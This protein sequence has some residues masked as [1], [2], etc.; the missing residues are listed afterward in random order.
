M[1][2][3]RAVSV[4]FAGLLLTMVIM[5]SFEET[6]SENVELSFFVPLIV[7]HAGNT[8]S[9][10]V[11]TVIRALALGEATLGD[12]IHITTKEF[13]TGG[14]IGICL[15]VFSYPLG[16]YISGLP[17]RVM[18]SVAVSLPAVSCVANLIGAGLPLCCE[19][20]QLDPAV[21]AAPM[22]TTM[23][24][25]SG[26]LTY[27]IISGFVIGHPTEEHLEAMEAHLEREIE[28]QFGVAPCAGLLEGGDAGR[29][30]KE[31]REGAAP[32][33]PP[34]PPTEEEIAAIMSAHPDWEID[35]VTGM[36]HPHVA[37][38]GDDTIG[39]FMN[40][41][42]VAVLCW[43]GYTFYKQR[44][45]ADKEEQPHDEEEG[46]PNKL[47]PRTLM[48]NVRRDGEDEVQAADL[49]PAP[50]EKM[51]STSELAGYFQEALSSL[52]A[53]GVLNATNA[54]A[55]VNAGKLIVAL[56]D[57]C[58]V[59]IVLRSETYN[60]MRLLQTVPL[61]K[62]MTAEELGRIAT[63]VE[64]CRYAPGEK[65]ITEGNTDQAMFVVASGTAVCTK[66][67]VNDGNP[68]MNYSAGDFF[69]ERA[70]RESHRSPQ[71]K[72][73]HD[74]DCVDGPAC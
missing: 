73:E 67:G 72:L 21:I 28:E 74:T 38:E 54:N 33:P 20:L 37:R 52:T 16:V 45:A 41:C 30:P 6:L 60:H 8:G 58:G 23:V 3:P 46:D 26:I 44:T 25:C 35:E 49:G 59:G 5:E 42:L 1:H 51:V 43:M 48:S 50:I 47:T 7:G 4:F 14:V 29:P 10:A 40:V 15:G 61:L 36:P 66:E 19:K 70:L 18:F 17:L 39:V 34:P 12:S 31:P 65:V 55:E 57:R 22:M 9:Q 11:S 71:P 2:M 53:K 63:N 62:G 32:S 68:I 24:D 27:L 13:I 56:A 69:G 64:V